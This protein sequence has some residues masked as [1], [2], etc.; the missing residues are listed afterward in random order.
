MAIVQH[1]LTAHSI[2]HNLTLY[3]PTDPDSQCGTEP[4][5]QK[6][7]GLQITLSAASVACSLPRPAYSHRPCLSIR[8][9]PVGCL[10]TEPAPH[11]HKSHWVGVHF[12]ALLGVTKLTY[13]VPIRFTIFVSHRRSRICFVLGPRATGN[14]ALSTCLASPS[15]SQ[16]PQL[17]LHTTRLVLSSGQLSIRK[18]DSSEWATD[19][20]IQIRFS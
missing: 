2:S 16:E 3:T 11:L 5:R 10:K 4:V 19:R 14:R 7:T 15:H 8:I 1:Q 18:H 17:E 9:A 20:Q 12:G 6:T 13:R